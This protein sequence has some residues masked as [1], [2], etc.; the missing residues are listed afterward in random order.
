MNSVSEFIKTLGPARLAAMGAVALG[1]VGFLA[2]LLIHFSQP[3]MSVLFTDLTLNDSIA[4]V[5]RLESM[6]VE[7]E[8]KQDGAVI[9]VPEDRVLRLRMTLAEDGLPAGGTVGYEIFDS[10][11][12]LG[13]TSFVQNINRLRAI[14]GELAR[15]IRAIDRVQTARVHLVLPERKL[16]ER[17]NSQPSASIVIK[18]RGMLDSGQIKAIQHLVASAVEGLKP[19]RVSIVDETGKLLASGRGDETNPVS[20]TL[21]EHRRSIELRTQQN[22][23][24]IVASIVGAGRARVRVSAEIDYNKITETSD[25]YDPEGQVV[26]STQTR[27]E[28]SSTASPAGD[29]GVSVGNELPAAGADQ[30]NGAKQR[31]SASKTEEVVNYEISKTTK[32]QIVEGG[33]VKRLSVA[34]LVDGIYTAG[35]DGKKTYQPRSQEELDEIA[36]LVRSAIGFDKERGDLVHVANLRFADRGDL[37]AA[38][39]AEKGM[40][41]LTPADYFHIAE[42]AVILLISLLVLF[43]VV[44]PLVRR[45]ITPEETKELED[46]ALEWREKAG[47]QLEGQ[48]SG[49]GEDGDQ[50]L[51]APPESATR[52][53]LQRA[54]IIGEVQASTI[55][56]VG[57]IVDNNPEEAITI[58]RSWL[59]E[60]AQGA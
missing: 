32:T 44:R 17:E 23:E 26:R 39:A 18:S 55:R 57:E 59:Q 54:K 5:K 53:A 38:D 36:A 30:N 7:H 58:V 60:G 14:E 43:F 41:D 6:N 9:L 33:R 13:A 12:S 11:D 49:N 40:L 46:L 29:G 2:F 25:I 51:L 15:T 34:V 4:V 19:E 21:D 37:I 28:N 16:F 3:K 42:L 52:S 31:D 1:L 48:G 20:A 50:A 8:I 24:D 27:E 47:K 10:T 56:E 35:P 45:I 22:V